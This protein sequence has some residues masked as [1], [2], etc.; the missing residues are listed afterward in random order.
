VTEYVCVDA[1]L[2]EIACV[3]APVDHTYVPPLGV[4]VAERLADTPEQIVTGGI[5]TFVTGLIVI[6]AVSAGPLHPFTVATTEY[7]NVTGLFVLLVAVVVNEFPV[8]T[9]PVVVVVKLAGN[10]EGLITDHV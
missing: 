5:E 3:V 8:V 7:V 2:T 10:G 9:L 4:P 1:G 6:F